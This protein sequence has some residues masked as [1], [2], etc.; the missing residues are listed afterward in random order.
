V[1][2]FT[3]KY[4]Q[5]G[6]AYLNGL[7]NAL[8]IGDSRSVQAIFHEALQSMASPDKEVN[9]KNTSFYVNEQKDINKFSSRI[10]ESVMAA[11]IKV[12][13]TGEFDFTEGYKVDA[14]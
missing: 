8:N 5:Y 10:L 7:G 2:G 3:E 11:L 14:I 9:G 6:D 1:E 13:I 4:Y 12:D